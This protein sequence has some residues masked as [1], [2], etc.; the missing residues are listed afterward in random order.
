[1]SAL[2]DLQSLSILYSVSGVAAFL[3][4]TYAYM[5]KGSRS[6]AEMKSLLSI[7]AMLWMINMSLHAQWMGASV[8]LVN[9]FRNRSSLQATGMSRMQKARYATIFGACYL[10]AGIASATGDQYFYFPLAAAFL[11]I[12]SLYYLQGVGTQFGMLGVTLLWLAYAV[13]QQNYYLLALQTV[14]IMSCAIG[15]HRTLNYDDNCQA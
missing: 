10:I 13:A 11:G 15:I 9:F 2:H 5:R 7:G 6:N 4:V 8:N 12:F 14:L 1:M 3:V